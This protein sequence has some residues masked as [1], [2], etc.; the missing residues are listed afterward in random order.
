MSLIHE[1]HCVTFLS[2]KLHRDM[3]AYWFAAGSC[4]PSMLLNEVM[5]RF[6]TF[7]ILNYT[8]CGIERE[9]IFRRCLVKTRQQV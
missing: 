7:L 1:K 3:C 4:V 6:F 2:S 5:D 9:K 8:V